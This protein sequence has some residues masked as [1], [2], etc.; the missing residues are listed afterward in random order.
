MI[1]RT[2]ISKDRRASKLRKGKGKE[3]KDRPHL[4]R[5]H[6]FIDVKPL[7]I[8]VCL[9]YMYMQTILHCLPEHFERDLGLAESGMLYRQSAIDGPARAL[10]KQDRRRERK[11]KIVKIALW[12]CHIEQ[13]SEG[14]PSLAKGGRG[15]DIMSFSLFFGARLGLALL[16]GFLGGGQRI[17]CNSAEKHYPISDNTT[18]DLRFDSLFRCKCLFAWTGIN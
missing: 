8:P 12:T 9:G 17:V 6:G 15:S 4:S 2:S 5:T 1:P 3:E 7:L 14:P 16:V 18:L 13:R 11:K 10:V